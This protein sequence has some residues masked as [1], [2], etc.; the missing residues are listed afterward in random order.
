VLTNNASFGVRQ[1]S[2][3]FNIGGTRDIPLVVEATTNL[4]PQS[5][6]ALQSC[7][8]TNGLIYFNDAQWTN[9]PSRIYRIR[10]P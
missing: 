4:A 6:V 8:L 10:S 5:W 9:Y 7:T 1:S 3:G 2:F